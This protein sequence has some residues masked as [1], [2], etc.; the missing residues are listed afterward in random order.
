M[1]FGH[2]MARPIPLAAP[3]QFVPLDSDWIDTTAA[4]AP[5]AAATT[6]DI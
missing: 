4:R 6:K 1:R 2:A 5:G 3:S